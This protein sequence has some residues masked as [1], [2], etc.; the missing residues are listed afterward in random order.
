M[1]T[2]ELTQSQ[3]QL[4]WRLIGVR[5]EMLALARET[6]MKEGIPQL[7]VKVAERMREIVKDLTPDQVQM[8]LSVADVTKKNQTLIKSILGYEQ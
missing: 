1:T 3:K 5:L 4:Q 7:P 2:K 6:L 8:C